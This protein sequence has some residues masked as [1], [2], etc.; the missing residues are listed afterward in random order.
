M[1]SDMPMRNFIN[2]KTLRKFATGVECVGTHIYKRR[3]P[4]GKVINLGINRVECVT[5]VCGS[6]PPVAS[7]TGPPIAQES[8]TER[9][10]PDERRMVERLHVAVHVKVTAAFTR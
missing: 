7:A 6:T 4:P 3:T 10:L 1:K 8:Q 2:A 5:Y 9:R